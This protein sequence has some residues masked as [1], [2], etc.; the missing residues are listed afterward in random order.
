MK[1]LLMMSVSPNKYS[2]LVWLLFCSIFALADGVDP[3]PCKKYD[4]ILCDACGCSATGGSLGMGGVLENNFLGVRYLRQ[5]YE[6]R[7]GIFNNSPMVK[8]TF[9]TVQFWSRIPVGKKLEMQVFVPYHSHNRE[10]ADNDIHIS[11]LGDITVLSNY[12]VLNQVKRKLDEDK[13]K[14]ITQNHR[15]KLGLGL[16]LPT[17]EYNQ[18]INNTK[19]PSFQLGTGSLDYLANLQYVYKYNKLGLSTNANYY[20]KTSNKKDFKFGNQF[21]FSSTFF[22]V[23][24][25]KKK[26]AL[27]PS[28]GFSGEFFGKNEHYNLPVADTKG[29]ALFTSLGFEYNTDRLT[30]GGLGAIPVSQNLAQGYVEAKYRASVYINYNFK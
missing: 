12:T 27:V 1:N 18:T 21:N 22:Y 13:G 2:I 25:N 8:E 15:L 6:S 28:I 11:G 17:G 29:Y 10:Y 24:T 26:Q 5:K 4:G 30:L 19:N 9:N 20:L 14:T 3:Y 16:K 23:H 7:D